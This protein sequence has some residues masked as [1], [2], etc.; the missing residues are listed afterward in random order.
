LEDWRYRE[1]FELEDRHW[2]FRA[3]RR[4]IASLLAREP[5]AIPAHPRRGL[6]HWEELA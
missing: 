5:A 3:R 4:V 2:W 1:Q 6:R